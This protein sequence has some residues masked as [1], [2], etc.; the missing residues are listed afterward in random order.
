MSNTE[1]SKYWF[2]A[3]RY[4]WGWGLPSRWQGWAVLLIYFVLVLAGIPLVQA[5]VGVVLY[6]V[7]ASALTVVLIGVCWLTGEPPRWRWGKRD[8]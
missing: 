3:K 6:L 2:P 5:K 8:V 1:K 4:G 7:Y